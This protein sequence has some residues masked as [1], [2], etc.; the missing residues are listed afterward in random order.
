MCKFLCYQHPQTEVKLVDKIL[1]F[2]LIKYQNMFLYVG[3][4]QL[5]ILITPS[6][7]SSTTKHTSSL[8]SATLQS[9]SAAGGAATTVWPKRGSD[10]EEKAALC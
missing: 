3:L 7:H 8:T 4:T 1:I 10:E 5:D 9:S 2:F 6:V